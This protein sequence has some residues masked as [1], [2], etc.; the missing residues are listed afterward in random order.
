MSAVPN[1]RLTQVLAAVHRIPGH[2]YPEDWQHEN[3]MYMSFCVGCTEHFTGGK[4]RFFCKKCKEEREA[5]ATA[6]KK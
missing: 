6:D 1:D 4:Y 2:D 3:G 5:T